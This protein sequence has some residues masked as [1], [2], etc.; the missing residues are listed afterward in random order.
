M[1][2]K[3]VRLTLCTKPHA[4]KPCG[5][6]AKEVREI[7]EASA[8]PVVV[9]LSEQVDEALKSVMLQIVVADKHFCGHDAEVLASVVY[10]NLG[11]ACLSKAA[12]L[13]RTGHAGTKDGLGDEKTRLAMRELGNHMT[14]WASI[15][16]ELGEEQ[17]PA[18][19]QIKEAQIGGRRIPKATADTYEKNSDRL[20][21]LCT[22]AEA[23]MLKLYQE[24]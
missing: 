21:D 13:Y 8:A 18:E 12:G 9:R 14:E 4:T 19:V 5:G 24:S 3:H 16:F 2:T 17:G 23:L 20:D 7:I 11:L 10:L 22:S 15:A 6:D 1:A